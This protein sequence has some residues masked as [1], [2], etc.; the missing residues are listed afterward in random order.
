M[1]H[2]VTWGRTV[3]L[4]HWEGTWAERLACGCSTL[5]ALGTVLQLEDFPLPL[6]GWAAR[7][8]A[9]GKAGRLTAPCCSSV[10]TQG[11]PSLHADMR[12]GRR[13]AKEPH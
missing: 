9:V 1:G 7:R 12:A 11:F 8:S 6:A 4:G 10:C 13:A 5:Q 3:C 2:K